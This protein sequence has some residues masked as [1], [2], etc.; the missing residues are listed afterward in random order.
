MFNKVVPKYVDHINGD[1]SDNRIENLRVATVQQ[2][3]FN[4]A[5]HKGSSSKYKGVSWYKRDK[6]WQASCCIDNKRIY[7]GKF[8]TE[9]EAAKAYDKA[10]T[11]HHKTYMKRNIK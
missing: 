6:Q 4:R 9:E 1:R 8:A 10:V 11:K 5:S 2:N 3:A 7:I